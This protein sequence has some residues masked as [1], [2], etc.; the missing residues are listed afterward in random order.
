MKNLLL[1]LTLST[2]VHA[3]FTLDELPININKEQWLKDNAPKPYIPDNM[4][5]PP[6][7]NYKTVSKSIH[8]QYG[9]DIFGGCKTKPMIVKPLQYNKNSKAVKEYNIL[10]HQFNLM[11]P[12]QKYNFIHRYDNAL[13]LK[14]IHDIKKILKDKKLVANLK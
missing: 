6:V 9:I 10:K 13:I 8:C 14:S 11:N 1:L 7:S 5:T 3:D 4:N 2:T 12:E